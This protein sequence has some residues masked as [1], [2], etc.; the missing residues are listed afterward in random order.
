MPQEIVLW[1]PI[2]ENGN[3][4]FDKV[5]NVCNASGEHKSVKRPPEDRVKVC[6][7]KPITLIKVH[8]NPYCW[9]VEQGG[10]MVERCY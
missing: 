9:W 2:D 1:I 6:E 4:V 3:V 8:K 5:S 7:I 10:E